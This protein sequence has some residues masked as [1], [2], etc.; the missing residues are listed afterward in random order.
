MHQ[1]SL[2]DDF[3]ASPFDVSLSFVETV[4][5]IS[6]VVVHKTE[7]VNSVNIYWSTFNRC[8]QSLIVLSVVS[9]W[10][11]LKHIRKQA[12]AI[13]L[14][15]C[16]IKNKFNL[17]MYISVVP[18]HDLIELCIYICCNHFA[19]HFNGTTKKPKLRFF[20]VLHD[21][22]II[23]IAYISFCFSRQNA[24]FTMSHS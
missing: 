19:A 1:W 5:P 15:P 20:S 7:Y 4:M 9:A 2:F 8:Y 17:Q 16:R 6:P 10:S 23:G 11:L 21:N 3:A 12:H 14:F 24:K 13:P 22:I 18:H